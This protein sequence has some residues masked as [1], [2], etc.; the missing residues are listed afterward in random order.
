MPPAPSDEP[1]EQATDPPTDSDERG[2]SVPIW[3]IGV[4]VA[5]LVVAIVVAVPIFRALSGLVFP[6]DPPLPPDVTELAHDNIAHGYDRWRYETDQ[7]VCEVATFYEAAGGTCTTADGMCVDGQYNSLG[8]GIEDIATCYGTDTFSIFGLRWELTMDIIDRR[9]GE[10][11]A[12]ELERETLW[13]GPA[14]VATSTPPA[15]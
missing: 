8:Y 15:P 12:F 1:A 11:T 6:A 2:R 3:L 13:A 9:E 7:N 14:P 4:A 10:F 5:A